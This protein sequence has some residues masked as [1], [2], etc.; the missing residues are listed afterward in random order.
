MKKIISIAMLLILASSVEAKTLVLDYADFGPQVLAHE[1]IGFQWFQ[2]NTQGPDSP[3]APNDP[4]KVVV[5]WDESINPVQQQYPVDQKSKKDYR[6]RKADDA[7]SYL[8]KVLQEHPELEH[9]KKIKAAIEK[10]KTTAEPTAAASAS[11]GQ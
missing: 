1:T 3:N 7:L 2:W 8:K 9:I 5:Y 4:I 10:A 6:Y 11:R